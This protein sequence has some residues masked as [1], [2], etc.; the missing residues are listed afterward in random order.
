MAHHARGSV[1]VL[2]TIHCVSTGCG[3]AIAEDGT[4]PA[5]GGEL[6]TTSLGTSSKGGAATK[7]SFYG[8]GGTNSTSSYGSTYST[9]SS[10]YPRGGGT[11]VG[12]TT[13]KGGTTATGG[14]KQI[15]TSKGGNSA[16]SSSLGG[17]S[18]LGGVSSRGGT[19]AA[20]GSWNQASLTRGGTSSQG[21]ST[22]FGGSIGGV[23]TISVAGAAW[24]PV[25]APLAGAAGAPAEWQGIT[26]YVAR[27]LTSTDAPCN[28]GTS[29]WLAQ[30]QS[31]LMSVRRCTADIDCVPLALTTA[32]GV[33]CPMQLNRDASATFRQTFQ[34]LADVACFS[35]P[36]LSTPG[37]MTI[38]VPTV[39]LGGICRS[40][41]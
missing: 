28:S 22:A 39:C 19:T 40:G 24:V 15:A 1:L 26:I 38:A 20:G 3:G 21:G 9:K 27:D 12:G 35:C 33:I 10:S 7:S 8:R 11:S 13:A 14:S 37:C 34:D 25:G 6:P 18:N 29:R 16:R 41:S 2:L 30:L 23:P 17:S 32:C 36:R 4:G 5:S 31:T